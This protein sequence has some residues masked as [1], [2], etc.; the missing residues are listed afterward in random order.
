MPSFVERSE[1][2]LEGVHPLMDFLARAVVAEFD[3]TVTDGFRTEAEQMKLYANGRTNSKPI[4]TN[5]DGVVKKSNHQSGRAIDMVPYPVDYKDTDRMAYFAGY[6]KGTAMKLGIKITWGG[7]W[8][9]DT[10]LKDNRFRDW[11]HFEL[12]EDQ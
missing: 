7:D 1:K 2:S 8:D 5:C 6:V 10:E 11:P 9:N 12:D 3:C 4:V